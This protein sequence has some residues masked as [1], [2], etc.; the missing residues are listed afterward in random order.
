MRSE[1]SSAVT[2]SDALAIL[3]GAVPLYSALAR[4]AELRERYF[5]KAVRIHILDNIKNGHCAEDG[6]DIPN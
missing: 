5:G 1:I 2:R 4:A 6:P 3:D